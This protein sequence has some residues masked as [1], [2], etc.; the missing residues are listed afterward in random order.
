MKETLKAKLRVNK[1]S[2]EMNPFVE[3]FIARVT[4]GAVASLR[5]AE[6]IKNLEIHRE[7]DNVKIILNGN[8]LPITPFPSEIISNTLVGL[9][10]SL[11]EMDDINNFD[12]SIETQ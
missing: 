9:I 8:E 10:S 11:K 1:I 12:I 5:E 6:D 3:E 4:L 7:K 2:V